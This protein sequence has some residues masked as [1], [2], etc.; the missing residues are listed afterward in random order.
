MVP[1]TG[2]KVVDNFIQLEIDNCRKHGIEVEFHNSKTVNTD[3]FE[4][5]GWFNEP[6]LVTAV[7][8]H[9][10][11]WVPVFIHESCHKDQCIQKVKAWNTYH[12]GL[13]AC[14]LVNDWIN[15][16]IELTDSDLDRA[17][18]LVQRV[19][20]D[21]EIRTV[22]KIK[23]FNL[24][25]DIKSFIKRANENIYFYTAAKLTRKW[26]SNTLLT[27]AVEDLMPTKFLNDYR[28][29]PSGYLDLYLSGS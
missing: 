13:D 4:V 15:H 14:Q 20:L 23:K 10:R 24:P 5:V 9:W 19:E 22:K 2:N 11:Q 16:T 21:C 1:H 25:L 6:Y 3:G 7:D 17:I 18:Y 28:T 27:D 29:L 8:Y 26:D 12:N